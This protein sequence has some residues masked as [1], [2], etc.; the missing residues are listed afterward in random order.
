MKK[1]QN[2]V[3]LGVIGA[4]HGIK[5]EVRVKPFTE[6]PLALGEYGPLTVEDGATLTIRSIRPAKTV[7]VVRFKE[8]QDRN[9]AKALNGK[10]LFVER[11]ALPDDLEEEE[12]YHA[13]LVGL[14]VQDEMGEPI[15]QVIAVHNFGAGDMLEIRLQGGHSAFIPFTKLAVPTVDFENGIVTVDRELAGLLDK[16]EDAQHPEERD[17]PEA[18]TK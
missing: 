1:L 11:E 9:A 4:P 17:G 7:V 18:D 12:F 10:A 5:G 2:P 13:D 16:E 6:D 3:Q 8:V 14:R 15:G